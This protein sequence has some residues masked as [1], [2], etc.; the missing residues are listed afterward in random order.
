MR[1]LRSATISDTPVTLRVPVGRTVCAMNTG[2]NR[3]DVGMPT[4]ADVAFPDGRTGFF[5]IRETSSMRGAVVA[6]AMTNM[7]ERVEP[8]PVLGTRPE[9]ATKPE[10]GS[11]ADP[12][13]HVESRQPADPT[14]EDVVGSIRV[15]DI[16]GLDDAA[17][18]DTVA[19]HMGP[20]P[21]AMADVLDRKSTRLNSSHVASSY[22]VFCWKT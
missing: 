11:H 17:A 8:V 21:P 9:P 20:V 2:A 15:A 10:P 3:R 1:T 7:S 5:G 13:R 19:S 14:I 16:L 12:E 4:L 18:D 6:F 22:A